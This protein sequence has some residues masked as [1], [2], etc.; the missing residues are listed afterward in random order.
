M[1]EPERENRELRRV[2][3]ILRSASDF[4][5]VELDHQHSR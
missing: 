5:A 1:A 2:N 3:A 4:F